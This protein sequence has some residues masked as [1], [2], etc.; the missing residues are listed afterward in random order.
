MMNIVDQLM[1]Y[2]KHNNIKVLIKSDINIEQENLNVIVIEILAWLRLEHKRSIWMNEGKMTSLKP[3]KI[4]MQYSW[5]VDLAKL[6][7]KEEM[8]Q[9][10]FKIERGNLSFSDAITENEQKIL[11]KKVYENYNPQKNT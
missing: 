7:D 5:C 11:R 3:L 9:K 2:R 4:N 6:V 8:F 10:Y 1:N